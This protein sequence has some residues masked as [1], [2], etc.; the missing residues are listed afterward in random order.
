MTQVRVAQV[1]NLQVA[2]Q[3]IQTVQ[4]DAAQISAWQ[5]GCDIRHGRCSSDRSDCALIC[6][7]TSIPRYAALDRVQVEWAAG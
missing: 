3:Q 2:I 7:S 6:L 1:R 4:I 5:E